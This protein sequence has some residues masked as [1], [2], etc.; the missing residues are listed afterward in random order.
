MLLQCAKLCNAYL[1]DSVI[2]QSKISN[3]HPLLIPRYIWFVEY[4][5]NHRICHFW[6]LSI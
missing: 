1:Y 5:C 2:F 4:F 6:H 3:L